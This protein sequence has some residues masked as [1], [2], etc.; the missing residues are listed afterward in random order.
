MIRIVNN[1]S[2]IWWRSVLNLGVC[3]EGYSMQKHVV[4]RRFCLTT[5][6]YITLILIYTCT[7]NVCSWIYT[8][9]IRSIL[10]MRGLY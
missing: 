1:I 3:D 10:E 4:Y 6:I 2:V 7:R 8:Y 5:F 9:N